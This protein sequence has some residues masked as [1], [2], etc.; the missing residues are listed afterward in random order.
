MIKRIKVK[1]M[2]LALGLFSGGVHAEFTNG[3]NKYQVDQEMIAQ[4]MAGESLHNIA[5]EAIGAGVSPGRVT[6]G[7]ISSG[8]RAIAVVRVVVGIA[9]QSA[10]DVVAA[11]ITEEPEQGA[12][13]TAAVIAMV[14]QQSRSIVTAA[15]TVPGVNP[16]NILSATAAGNPAAR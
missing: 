7:L 14:P 5:K 12:A 6:T 3:M 9:P 11:A 10:P 16:A 13:I 15:I 4:L 2:V 1:A 8:E